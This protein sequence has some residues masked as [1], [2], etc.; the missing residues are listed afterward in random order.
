MMER[1][2]ARVSGERT[3]EEKE[4]ISKKFIEM[5][6]EY[7]KQIQLQKVL[8]NQIRLQDSEYRN[9]LRER[10]DLEAERE[11]MDAVMNELK[12]QTNVMQREMDQVKRNK[13]N[14]LVSH[15]VMK[16]EE[17]RLREEWNKKL[18]ST[19]ALENKKAQL[20]I[21]MEERNKEI[22]A[23]Q[24]VLKAQL[25]VSQEEKHALSIQLSEKNAQVGNARRR[26]EN[27]Q[28]KSNP[29]GEERLSQAQIILKAAREK[30]SLQR[31]GDVLDEKIRFAEKELVAMEAMLVDHLK[32]RNEQYKASLISSGAQ[33]PEAVQ[34]QLKLQ[35]QYRAIK[36]VRVFFYMLN[37]S[38]FFTSFVVRKQILDLIHFRDRKI[39]A[40]HRSTTG[41][42]RRDPKTK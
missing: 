37:E 41:R 28:A 40:D 16:L 22:E 21:S 3:V 30:E 39:F 36:D 24:N 15:D 10:K 34:Q 8:K 13:E 9:R 42:S 11:R 12:M 38:S 27:I 7:A 17:R 18:E 5:E 32:P 14:T 25:R 31:Q 23:H 6:E 33:D 1:K 19:F 2:V 4:Q 20:A 35:E 29:E 26:F